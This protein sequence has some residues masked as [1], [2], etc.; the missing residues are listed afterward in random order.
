MRRQGVPARSQSSMCRIG[1]P[2][3]GGSIAAAAGRRHDRIEVLPQVGVRRDEAMH[4][5]G[6]IDER[7]AEQLI[8]EWRNAERPVFLSLLDAQPGRGFQPAPDS[9]DSG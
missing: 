5:D 3:V 1:L 6:A 2:E 7:P 4:R 8:A 9:R